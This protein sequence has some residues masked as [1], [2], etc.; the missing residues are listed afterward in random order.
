MLP[1]SWAINS[2]DRQSLHLIP[3]LLL[4]DEPIFSKGINCTGIPGVGAQI[5]VDSIRYIT[6]LL[7]RPG[8]EKRQQPYLPNDA[9]SLLAHTREG[10]IS[11]CQIIDSRFLSSAMGQSST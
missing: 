4:Y 5:Q 10:S 11:N 3:R 9:S 2:R 8:A 7:A 6:T 1:S